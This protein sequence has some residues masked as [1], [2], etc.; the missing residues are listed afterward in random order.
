MSERVTL[1]AKI[2]KR[3]RDLRTTAGL[4]QYE[5]AERTGLTRPKIKRIEKREITTVSEEDLA[6]RKP[7]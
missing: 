3:M 6:A 5:L 4:S 1:T 7:I 2:S